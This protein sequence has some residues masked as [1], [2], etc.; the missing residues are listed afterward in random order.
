M[1]P[2]ILPEGQTEEWKALKLSVK[3]A[4]VPTWAQ[5]SQEGVWTLGGT[6]GHG[7]GKQVIKCETRTENVK[8]KS[9]WERQLQ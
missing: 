5:R 6:M 9:C 4:N 3:S 1:I 7:A 8:E 2:T